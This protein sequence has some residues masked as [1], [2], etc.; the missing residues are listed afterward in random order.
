[1]ER[2]DLIQL[3]C[4]PTEVYYRPEIF[5]RFERLKEQ[6][7][8]QHLGVSVQKVEEAIKAIEYENVASVQIIF[9]VFRQRPAELF[10]KEAA[11]RDVGIIVR[12]PLASGLLTGKFNSNT[13]FN[14][15]DHRFFNRKGEAFDKGETF[16]GID[17]ETG[18]EAMERM[19]KLFP[20]VSNLAPI[21]LQWILEYKEVSCIIP[22]ASSSEQVQSNLSV[23]D[24]KGA[25]KENIQEMNRIYNEMIRKQVHHL[26]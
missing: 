2:L 26:W 25:G 4:P 7:K 16:S 8:I 1:M 12:V 20:D 3:H 5:E 22:G 15:G 13:T 11:K 17:Y 10:F 21:A 19:K 14:S 9:N 23:Y 24:K 6:G 18:L